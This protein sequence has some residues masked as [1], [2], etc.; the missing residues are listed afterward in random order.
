MIMLNLA[1]SKIMVYY[2]IINILCFV[3]TLIYAFHIVLL[4]YVSC[5]IQKSIQDIKD[6]LLNNQLQDIIAVKLIVNI[7][8]MSLQ[9][10]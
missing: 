1:A 9:E 4:S 10:Y 3:N 5:I 8:I 7:W 6:M 2:L